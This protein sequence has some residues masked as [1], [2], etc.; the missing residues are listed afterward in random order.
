MRGTVNLMAGVALAWVAA[1]P[2]AT[3]APVDGRA[4]LERLKALAGAWEGT[5]VSETGP[6][7]K[8]VYGVTAAGTAVTESLFPGT[9]HEMLTVYHLEG[10]DLVLT[11]YC[12]MG[13]QPRM[14][15]A[16]ASGADPFELHF[17]FAGGTNLVAGK[18]AHMHSGRMTLRGADRLE[19][20]WAVYD[21]GKQAGSNRFFLRR[22]KDR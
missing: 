21:K 22:V 14:K 4:A 15:L 12:A 20:E 16:Q 18:D 11:H 3:A 6:R 5:V 13:N 7:T 10:N 1:A 8:V 19:A 9:D 2:A 17:E